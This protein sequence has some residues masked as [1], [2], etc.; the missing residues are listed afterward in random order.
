[1]LNMFRLL[2]LSFFFAI[3]L[4]GCGGG[5]G[6]QTT[7]NPQAV[8]KV[9]DVTFTNVT[10]NPLISSVMPGERSVEVAAFRIVWKDQ[11]RYPISQL[12]FKN[13]HTGPIGETFK[14]FQLMDSFGNDVAGEASYFVRIDDMKQ[15][16]TVDFYGYP[17]NVF[18]S[19]TSVPKTYSLLASIAPLAK[20]G[21]KFAF[22]L[23]SVQMHDAGKDVASQVI[24]SDFQVMKVAGMGLPMVVGST[25]SSFDVDIKLVGSGN[26]LAVGS[27]TVACPTGNAYVC[28]FTDIDYGAYG[29]TVPYL[30][31]DGTVLSSLVTTK[32]DGTY[33]SSFY[34][35]IYPGDSRTFVMNAGVFELPPSSPGVGQVV[36][37]YVNDLVFQM[38]NTKVSPVI[39]SGQGDCGLM[40]AERS[41][42]KG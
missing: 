6:N 22:T 9:V 21:Q 34:Y 17:W 14:K 27:F 5:G 38:G 32:P 33:H 3:S 37:I 10:T 25:S 30:T 2:V 19:Q 42:C 31:V 36:Y 13:N 40:V 20:E 11:M 39:P 24:G 8:K 41:G 18:D 7:T 15:E 23:A 26:V 16:I 35:V 28:I 1:M 12:V 4:A 29:S